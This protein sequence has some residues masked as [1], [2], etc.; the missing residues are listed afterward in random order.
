MGLKH[1][2]AHSIIKGVNSALSLVVL[3]RS[4]WT[5]ETENRSR[6]KCIYGGGDELS[7][8]VC[9]ERAYSGAKLGASVG[10]FFSKIRASQDSYLSGNDQ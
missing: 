5:R 9:L 2:C 7:T 3:L 6:N 10:D 8:I 4:A 1:E